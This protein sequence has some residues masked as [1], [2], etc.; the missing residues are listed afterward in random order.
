V[1]E[2]LRF[3]DALGRYQKDV[4]TFERL[5]LGLLEPGA[6]DDRG[7]ERLV[8]QTR[9]L[10]AAFRELESRQAAAGADEH[11]LR[12]RLVQVAAPRPWRHVVVAG[13]TGRAIPTVS[14]RPTGTCWRGCPASASRRRGHDHARRRPAGS[15]TI[16]CP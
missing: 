4:D 6:A 16:C 7:A 14:G 3:Y 15:C 10:S 13:A 12:A 2:V 11:L 5:A 9:F 8:R 1:A